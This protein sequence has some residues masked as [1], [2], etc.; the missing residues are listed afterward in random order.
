MDPELL[1]R[2]VDVTGV[3]ANALLGAAL[4]RAMRFDLIGFLVMSTAT[5]LGG[6]MVRDMLLGV[7]F[8]VALTDPLYLAGAFTAATISYF[9][10]F[11]SKWSHR[12]LTILDALALG[13]WSATGASKGLSAGLGW[14]PSIFLGVV[15]ATMGGITRDVLVN[16]IPSVFGGNPLYATFSILAAAQM[17]VFQHAGLYTAGM[18]SAIVMCF[19]FSL[20]ARYFK[21]SL[22]EPLNWRV[23]AN[24]LRKLSPDWLA[25]R[26]AG[27]LHLDSLEKRVD[28]ENSSI[29]DTSTRLEAID[30]DTKVNPAKESRARRRDQ[31]NNNN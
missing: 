11:Q 23:T 26:R 6:G 30:P 16:R 14:M 29:T 17:V 1:F 25:K 20:L 2:L 9:I 31:L 22:P 8:P 5:A 18:T 3:I 7:G 10:S 21:W 28:A 15:T 12:M 13:C 19:I 27:R 24:S 4:A